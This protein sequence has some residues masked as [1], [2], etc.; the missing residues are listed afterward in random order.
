M[1]E[2]LNKD[3]INREVDINRINAKISRKYIDLDDET[4]SAI[5]NEIKRSGFRLEFFA[6]QVLMIHKVSLARKLNKARRFHF[7]ELKIIEKALD[8][9]LGTMK[10]EEEELR[11]E[12]DRIE[13]LKNR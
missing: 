13:R 5:K 10:I 8:I 9:D 11:K 7:Y 3:T 6:E 4:L 2:E 12:K 1:K